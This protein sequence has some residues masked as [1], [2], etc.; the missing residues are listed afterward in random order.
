MVGNQTGSEGATPTHAESPRTKMAHVGLTENTPTSTKIDKPVE[1]TGRTKPP[2][3]SGVHLSTRD[4]PVDYGE[5]NDLLKEKYGPARGEKSYQALIDHPGQGIHFVIGNK[6]VAEK[7]AMMDSL[8]KVGDH[9]NH[10]YQGLYKLHSEKATPGKLS[11]APTRSRFRH[12]LR[13]GKARMW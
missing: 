13:Q 6:I 11:P 8:G 9:R 3:T 7:K 2:D 1:V 10:N 5:V 12:G 4:K